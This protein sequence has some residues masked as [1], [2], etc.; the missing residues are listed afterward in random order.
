MRL[1]VTKT[2]D[3]KVPWIPLGLGGEAAQR[4][5]C[6]LPFEERKTE[7]NLKWPRKSEFTVCG[8]RRDTRSNMCSLFGGWA[9]NH[10]GARHKHLSGPGQVNILLKYE[11][12][13]ME[14]GIK[15]KE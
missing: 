6:L 4:R 14:K 2:R 13:Y 10:M 12:M 7:K 3:A 9:P 11:N 5:V 15:K 8:V 1:T